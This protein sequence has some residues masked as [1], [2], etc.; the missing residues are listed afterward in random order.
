MELLYKTTIKE[1]ADAFEIK[2]YKQYPKEALY[3]FQ[4]RS[5]DGNFYYEV[6]LNTD[7][8]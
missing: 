7:W 6:L 1:E 4:Y 3:R 5:T 8:L 2:A